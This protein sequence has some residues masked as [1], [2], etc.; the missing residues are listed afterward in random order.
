[1]SG[2]RLWTILVWGVAFLVL[3]GVVIARNWQPAD[4]QSA[5]REMPVNHFLR[6]ADLGSY[7]GRDAFTGKY[8]RRRVVKG[9][10]LTVR[11][12]S[13]MPLLPTDAGPL[14]VIATPVAG[15]GTSVE[16]QKK[17]EI[18]RD[19]EAVASADVVAIACD[20][21]ENSATCHALVRAASAAEMKKLSERLVKDGPT[22]FWFKASC[23]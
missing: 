1:M 23:K 20:P 14:F 15:V 7:V 11:D 22:N 9:E 13:P 12:V 17:G 8:L 19:T 5:V 18:C 3:L 10:T 2:L 16:A 4:T 6:H 21:P